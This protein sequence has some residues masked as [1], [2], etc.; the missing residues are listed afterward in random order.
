MRDD[1]SLLFEEKNYQSAL[2]LIEKELANIK[3]I[4]TNEPEYTELLHARIIAKYYLGEKDVIVRDQVR[5][6][7]FPS[8]TRHL[9][10]GYYEIRLIHKSSFQEKCDAYVNCVNIR[11]PFQETNRVS[12]SIE[13]TRALGEEEVARQI[14]TQRNKSRGEFLLLEHQECLLR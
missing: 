5:K 4:Q 2:A 9:V 1:I 13:F 7:I 14:K 3:D 6:D 11:Q 10:E 12:A 8:E